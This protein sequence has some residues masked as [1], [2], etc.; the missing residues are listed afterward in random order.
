MSDQ[1]NEFFSAYITH[2]RNQAQLELL[3]SY[4]F[5]SE[6]YELDTESDP[7]YNVSEGDKEGGLMS[8]I[9]ERFQQV[10]FD[11][12]F[13]L[14]LVVMYIKL[15]IK[16]AIFAAMAWMVNRL[17]AGMDKIVDT[18]EREEFQHGDD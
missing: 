4:R 16:Q 14:N 15:K 8:K 12:L 6:T 11:I 9:Q 1:T 10:C 13:N 17:I 3:E 18:Y 7:W 5:D 2:I